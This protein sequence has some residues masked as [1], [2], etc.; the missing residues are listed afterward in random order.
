MVSKASVDLPLPESPVNTVSVSRG[1]WTSMFLRLFSLAPLIKIYFTKL[2]AYT[3]NRFGFS[4]RSQLPHERIRAAAVVFREELALLP[5]KTGEVFVHGGRLARGRDKFAERHPEVFPF[6]GGRQQFA[7]PL[8]AVEHDEVAFRRRAVRPVH[9]A[10]ELQRGDAQP[11][12]LFRLAHGGAGEALAALD[13]P[14]REDE[15]VPLPLSALF[16]G[17]EIGALFPHHHHDGE[18]GLLGAAH[19][20][21][22]R[23]MSPA[24]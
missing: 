7:L 8:R 14:A 6:G 5:E 18:F 20:S 17:D 4:D 24:M 3:F 22:L 2:I 23:A 19:S 1:M 12:L 13:V 10:A 15:P 9:H 16:D 21:F 11:R